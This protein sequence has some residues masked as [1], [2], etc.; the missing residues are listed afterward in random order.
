MRGLR[1]SAPDAGAIEII[2]DDT[3]VGFASQDGAAARNVPLDP[4]SIIN[5][6]NHG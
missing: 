1:L 4:Q 2:L 6:Q 5:R 3:T